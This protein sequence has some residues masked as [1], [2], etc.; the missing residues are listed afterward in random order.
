MNQPRA[1]AFAAS[2]LPAGFLVERATALNIGTVVV[3]N[4]VHERSYAHV[5][6]RV[7]G[8]RVERL[9]GQTI[10][11]AFALARRFAGARMSGE[12]IMFFHECCWPAFDLLIWLL[13]PAGSFFPQVTMASFDVAPSGELG[14]GRRALALR[15]LS[16]AFTIY[17]APKNSGMPGYDYFPSFR[18]YPPSIRIF[19]VQPRIHSRGTS[20]PDGRSVIFI[21]GTEVGIADEPLRG[22]YTALMQTARQSGWSVFFKDHPL[23]RLSV[24]L[25]DGCVALDAALPIELIDREFTLAVG[26][27]STAILSVGD[28]KLSLVRTLEAM[29]QEV[30]DARTRHLK[31]LPGG[32]AVEFPSSLAA[33]RA[34]LLDARTQAG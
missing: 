15:L 11:V 7:P 33:V 18:A 16:H 30:Q 1:T 34:A 4:D 32:D 23:A 2:L 20:C 17:R 19:P 25:P 13:R 26:V 14:T 21:G 8:L 22:M 28:R 24:T 9:R 12:P 5:A 31:A 29:P 10:R 6:A 3:L 27:A